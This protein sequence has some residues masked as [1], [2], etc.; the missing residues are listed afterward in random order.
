[1]FLVIWTMFFLMSEIY[2]GG[3]KGDKSKNFAFTCRKD[4]QV[5]VSEAFLNQKL[6]QMVH[7]KNLGKI[8]KMD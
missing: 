6:W 8:Y 7:M 5:S 2:Q 3:A 1:M 4:A